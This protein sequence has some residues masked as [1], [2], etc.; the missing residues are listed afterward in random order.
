MIEF[1]QK[2]FSEY[3]AMRQL[4]VELDKLGLFR[5]RVI[6]VIDKSALIPILK[7]NNIV[8]E[9]FTQ[10]SRIFGKDRYR[11][12][13]KIGA[14]AKMPD[15]VRLPQYSRNKSLGNLQLSLNYGFLPNQGGGD[16]NGGNNNNQ[17]GNNQSNN[18]SSINP[19]PNTTPNNQ[20]G[21]SQGGNGGKNQ[22]GKGKKNGKN[23]SEISPVES[24]TF[25]QK[26]FGTP[27][28][29]NVSFRPNIDFLNYQV[30]T[31]LGDAIKYDK[32]ERSLVLEFS[33]ID[34]AIKALNILPFGLGY[35]IYLLDA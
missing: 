6:G 2:Q 1:R 17:Q 27:P 11:M 20:Q 25:R 3:D 8:I 5:N 32:R 24:P 18:Q 22:P 34:D 10:A 16:N 21:Q 28:V 15:E 19:G 23:F 30:H 35:K 26:E 14:K 9:K 29:A 31:L 33:S 12:Y 4:Y 13:L 7:G